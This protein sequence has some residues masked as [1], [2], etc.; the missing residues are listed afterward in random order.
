[1]ENIDISKMF[2]QNRSVVVIVAIVLF[3][4]IVAKNIYAK[5]M[6]QYFSIKEK[7]SAEAEKNEA[8][9][10]IVLLNEQ[11]QK[12][13]ARSW[14][15]VDFNAIVEK[16]FNMGLE[17]NVKIRDITPGEK[18]DEPNYVGIPFSISGETTYSDLLKFIKKLETFPMLIQVNTVSVNPIG[19]QEEE[20]N[21][22]LGIGLGAEAIY[23]K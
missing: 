6:G 18:R 1:M 4:G 15:T 5:Q 12:K 19:S 22:A 13:R 16:I 20:E 11:V 9:E 21:L 7:I 3:S 8:I 2:V 23:F 14:D 17:Y 10:R